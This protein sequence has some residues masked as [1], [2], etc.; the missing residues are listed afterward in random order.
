MQQAAIL[1]ATIATQH[2]GLL[3]R[4]DNADA[5][6]GIVAEGRKYVKNLK[7]KQPAG[8]PKQE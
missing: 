4:L 5:G 3:Y 8:P 1:R 7:P 6:T 2:P